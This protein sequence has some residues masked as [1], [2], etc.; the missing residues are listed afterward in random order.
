MISY[1]L[2]S[3]ICIKNNDFYIHH[4]AISKENI[5]SW[6]LDKGFELVELNPVLDDDDADDDTEGTNLLSTG[7]KS[8][9]RLSC[10]NSR[11]MCDVL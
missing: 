11:P 10:L 2:C 8:V 1:P 7:L 9:I 4:T 6:C 3:F 5:W